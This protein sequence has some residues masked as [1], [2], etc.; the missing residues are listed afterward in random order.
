MNIHIMG[1]FILLTTLSEHQHSGE[2]LAAAIFLLEISKI[3]KLSFNILYFYPYDS[4]NY[5]F[6]SS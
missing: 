2:T 6:F 5:V 3:V 4:G 1:Y